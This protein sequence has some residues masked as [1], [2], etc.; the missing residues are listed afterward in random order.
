[1]EEDECL[2]AVRAFE[3]RLLECFSMCDLD[4]NG[5]VD[6]YDLQQILQNYGQWSD[7]L[8]RRMMAKF[9]QLVKL[10]NKTQKLNEDD[11][12]QVMYQLSQS[13]TE[14]QFIQFLEK[15]QRCLSNLSGSS[16]EAKRSKAIWQLFN[17]WDT[18]ANGY[19]KFDDIK[20]IIEG[21]DLAND[22]SIRKQLL[23][24]T[25]Q[26]EHSRRESLHTSTD[27]TAKE[28]NELSPRIVMGSEDPSSSNCLNLAT[29]HK[30]LNDILSNFDDQQFLSQIDEIHKVLDARQHA[31]MFTRRASRRL[32]SIAAANWRSPSMVVDQSFLEHSN[33]KTVSTRN[34]SESTLTGLQFRLQHKYPPKSVG[35][36]FWDGRPLDVFVHVNETKRG[37][38]LDDLFNRLD[39]TKEDALDYYEVRKAIEICPEVKSMLTPVRN[40]LVEYSN[41]LSAMESVQ[42]GQHDFRSLLLRISGPLDDSSFNSFLE[43]LETNW[44]N[45]AQSNIAQKK[46]LA[47]VH[48]FQRWDE[49]HNGL[50]T[51]QDLNQLLETL[52][53]S[54]GYMSHKSI[55]KKFATLLP[56]LREMESIDQEQ[57]LTIVKDLLCDLSDE[58][59]YLAIVHAYAKL[60]QNYP[61]QESSVNYS[62]DKSDSLQF[63]RRSSALEDGIVG[64]R[65]SAVLMKGLGGVFWKEREIG[66]EM[67]ILDLH[68]RTQ[69][70][71]KLFQRMDINGVGFLD[72]YELGQVLQSM[73]SLQDHLTTVQ[74]LLERVGAGL[75]LIDSANRI[76]RDDFA[77]LLNLICASLNNDQYSAFLK[78]IEARFQQYVDDDI[79]KKKKQAVQALF[80]R[81]DQEAKGWLSMEEF[82][83][84]YKVVT[85]SQVYKEY[86]SI[87]KECTKWEMRIRAMDKHEFGYR[88][89]AGEFQ[90]IIADVL[91][92]LGNEGFYAAVTQFHAQLD[93]ELSN[94]VNQP[95]F[96]ATPQQQTVSTS[97]VTPKTNNVSCD[98]HIH[99]ISE[100]EKSLS[101]AQN[102]CKQLQDQL[103]ERET[104]DAQRVCELQSMELRLRRESNIIEELYEKLEKMETVQ[105][106]CES[107]KTRIVQLETMLND[108]K[109]N[110]DKFSKLVFAQEHNSTNGDSTQ[111]FSTTNGDTSKPRPP[112]SLQ[113]SKS[114]RTGSSGYS[115]SPFTKSSPKSKSH[116]HLSELISLNRMYTEEELCNTF[117]SMDT[118]N[119]GWISKDVLETI[120]KDLDDFSLPDPAYILKQFNFLGDGKLSYEE[121]C[122]LVLQLARR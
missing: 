79:E 81:W 6:F 18:E 13:C 49:N 90:S 60:D 45:I 15:V 118:D 65:G 61:K 32:V 4:G 83:R 52:K 51:T 46:Q 19:V 116:L 106:Q 43:S 71:F 63:R 23:K 33:S 42:M 103:N 104:R 82:L 34:R 105:A 121:F 107:Y 7:R 39:D 30:L 74:Q 17:R 37:Q 67:P 25:N 55:R 72:M 56:Q 22:K 27:N 20:E 92:C 70:A 35:A 108:A 117:R 12:L 114:P 113:Y 109:H 73:D 112:I 9:A 47:L 84:F 120:L 102:T 91:K 11:F 89:V 50:I 24:W 101:L 2:R 76:Q 28:Q 100:L 64:R 1:M 58:E 85:N 75:V 87:R 110:A 77:A 38:G 48:L 119:K 31:R 10:M 53:T 8:S 99:R 86:R 54:N 69:M 66:T 41:A 115:L 16:G 62:P 3:S 97:P 36:S 96:K 21:S 111:H 14:D 93:T 44:C 5:C 94:T 88:I 122:I 68:Q 57:F 78:A 59:F 26:I 95:I 80:L 40:L 98:D 29:F